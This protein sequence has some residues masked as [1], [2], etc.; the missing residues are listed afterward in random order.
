MPRPAAVGARRRLNLDLAEADHDHP[1]AM[2]MPAPV[3][4]PLRDQS[5]AAFIPAWQ[6]GGW[7]V[8]PVHVAA[9]AHH[10][11]WMLLNLQ[12]H[13]FWCRRP[14]HSVIQHPLRP[15]IAVGVRAHELWPDGV[16]PATAVSDE[17]YLGKLSCA[18][19]PSLKS[20]A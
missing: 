13:R 9:R 20:Q 5:T 4:A 18:A 16:F 2:P 1:A 6:R 10:P 11:G 12:L 3:H 8:V 15:M 7:A 19:S 14:D 17:L